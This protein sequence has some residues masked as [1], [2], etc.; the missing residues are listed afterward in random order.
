MTGHYEIFSRF[1]GSFELWVKLRARGRKQQKKWTKYNYIFNNWKKTSI[2][3]NNL[4]NINNLLTLTLALMYLPRCQYIKA[5]VWDFPVM[6]E[7][8]RLLI[9]YLLHGLFRA[10]LKKNT[11]KTLIFHIR[12]RALR[13]S[14]SL[15]LKKYLYASFSFSHWKYSCTLAN[16]FLLFSPTRS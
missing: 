16:L 12:L 8:T 9:S 15:I 11:I 3:K 7:R 13:L 2:E 14:S 10:I 5:S 1:N 4:C 6:T